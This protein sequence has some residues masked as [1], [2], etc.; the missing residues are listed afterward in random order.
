MNKQRR[1]EIREVIPLL[2]QSLDSLSS[3]LFDEEEALENLPENLQYSERGEQM[4]NNVDTLSDFVDVL[5]NMIDELEC[6]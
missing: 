2:Q 3:V 4:Q 1:S 6:M 5:Q